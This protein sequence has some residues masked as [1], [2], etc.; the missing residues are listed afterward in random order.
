MDQRPLMLEMKLTTR[1]WD[2]YIRRL[3]DEADLP[4]TYRPTLMFVARCP[5]VSQKA[6]AEHNRV[7]SASVSQTVRDMIAEGY[8]YREADSDDLRSSHLFLTE[9]G[10]AADDRIREKVRAAERTVSDALTPGELEETFRILRRVQEVL[11]A[12]GDGKKK[13]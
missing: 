9:K 5:G 13:P 3:A 10:K 6:I 2:E 1:A 11:G 8:L 7:T 12:A 4:D